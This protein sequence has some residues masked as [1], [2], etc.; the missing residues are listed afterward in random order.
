[1]I[2]W[3]YVMKQCEGYENLVAFMLLTLSATKKPEYFKEL[4]EV[5]PEATKASAFFGVPIN[6]CLH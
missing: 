2:N 4:L 5:L 1:M 3:M 6:Q